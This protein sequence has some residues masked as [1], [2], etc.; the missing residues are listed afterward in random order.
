M[1]ALSKIA[2]S[3]TCSTG[4]LPSGEIAVNH[5]GL[6]ERST[7]IRRNGTCFSVSEMTARCT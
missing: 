2:V 1:T 3:P 4:V 6:F 7:S 5:R